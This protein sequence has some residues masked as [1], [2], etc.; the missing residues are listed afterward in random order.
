MYFSQ[1]MY[2][3]F[4]KYIYNSCERNMLSCRDSVTLHWCA[5]KG[6]PQVSSCTLSL[7]THIPIIWGIEGVLKPALVMS[8]SSKHSNH[9]TFPKP[10][11]IF[12]SN[13]VSSLLSWIGLF[14]VKR[15]GVHLNGYSWDES[16][17]LCM[18]L[19]RRSPTKQTYP[20]RLDNLVRQ[21]TV[22]VS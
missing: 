6:Q 12:A 13:L 1:N 5:W 10:L 2:Y 16:G 9:S 18:W 17:R 22:C 14:G 21:M 7:Y 8:S 15:Y 4:L 20:G 19:G 11:D 3:A